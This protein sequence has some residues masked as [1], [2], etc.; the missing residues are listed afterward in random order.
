MK[1]K[2]NLLSLFVVVLIGITAF[3]IYKLD[4]VNKIIVQQNEIIQSIE[5]KQAKDDLY[6]RGWIAEVHNRALSNVESSTFEL[7]EYNVNKDISDFIVIKKNLKY[8]I[9]LIEMSLWSVKL[10]LL[11]FQ[12]EH[13]YQ[14]IDLDLASLIIY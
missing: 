9:F 14:K 1:S 2:E 6:L 5:I 12:N 3:L 8:K 4:Q 11:G 13:L 10:P 7:F